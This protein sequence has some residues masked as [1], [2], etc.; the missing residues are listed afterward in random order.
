VSP[1]LEVPLEPLLLWP[2][3]P[4]LEVPLLPLEPLEPLDPLDPPLQGFTLTMT[5]ASDFPVMAFLTI[6]SPLSTRPL[7]RT[8]P[9]KVS[10]C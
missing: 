5:Q 2:L 7:P 6:P 1:L 3:E 10:V 9:S 8:V 4:L